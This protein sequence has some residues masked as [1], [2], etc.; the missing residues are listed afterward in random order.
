[1]YIVRRHQ[2]D[3]HNLREWAEMSFSRSSATDANK[4]K[5]NN[6]KKNKIKILHVK[7][8]FNITHNA[9]QYDIYQYLL[10]FYDNLNSINCLLAFNY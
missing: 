3:F 9:C 5:Y 4:N 8:T 7:F 2:R 6:K 1:M 10:L